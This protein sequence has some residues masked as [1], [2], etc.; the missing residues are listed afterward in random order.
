MNWEETSN[1]DFKSLRKAVGHKQMQIDF[2]EKFIEFA[3]K[4]V[5]EDL[6]KKYASAAMSGSSNTKNTSTGT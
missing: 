2:Y 1:K 3:S 6:K 5:G 4:E